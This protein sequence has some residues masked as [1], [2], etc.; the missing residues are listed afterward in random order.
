[1]R[2]PA[3]NETTPLRVVPRP[4][5]VTTGETVLRLSG[6][7]SI[8]IDNSSS[9]KSSI[10]RD[11]EQAIHHTTATLHK[12]RHRYLS[13]QRGAEF[14]ISGTQHTEIQK[15]ILSLNGNGK[16]RS[17]AHDAVLPV[18]DRVAAERYEL[19]L[20]TDGSAHIEADT[21]LGLY[22]G[23]TT[24]QQLFFYSGGKDGFQYTPHAPINIEDQPAFGWRAVL[25]DTSRNWFGEEALLKMLDTMALIK[26]NVFHWHIT[27]SNSWPLGLDDFPEL[28]GK[29]AYSPE[30][31][32]Q[33][34][35]IQKIVL[36]ANA[37]GIDVVPEIDMPGHTAI[38]AESHPELIAGYQRTPFVKYAHQPP[39][40]QLRFADDKVTEWTKGLLQSAVTVFSSP[41]FGTGGDELNTTCMMED[42]ETATTLK[43]KGWTLEKAL[44][45]FTE[46]THAVV[47]A[48]KKTPLVWQ[49]MVL[50]HGD[51]PSVKKDTLVSIWIDSKDAAKVLAKG[52]RIVHA[53]ADYFYLDQGQGGWLGEEGGGDS[54]QGPYKSWQKMYS[55][56]PYK[57]V[58]EGKRKLVMGG[59]CSLWAEQTDETNLET[60][61]WPRAAAVAELFWTG[62]GAEGYPRSSVEAF[63]RMHDVR[64]RMVDRGVRA[65]PLQPYWSALRPGTTNK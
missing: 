12:N 57:D 30:E 49:E 52:F 37:R 62:A 25:L 55:F 6:D 29:G 21:S 11:L 2:S 42:E 7:F 24:F 47:R 51:L 41:Y 20:A 59:Q 50:T 3:S 5:R 60:V 61:L 1:M 14:L 13:P 26:M 28:A 54:W 39:A 27:D 18:E 22:R 31:V 9:L 58:E 40:G 17:I 38:I 65:I 48:N 16:P 53:A 23:L 15:L 8:D 36:Y 43:S 45:N 34:K 46:Q 35:Q 4:T 32:Y 10:P 44:D 33:Q 56:D 64:F 63:P 19:E